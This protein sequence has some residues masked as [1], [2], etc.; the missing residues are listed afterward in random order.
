MNKTIEYLKNTLL[1]S[2]SDEEQEHLA[3]AIASLYK[4]EPMPIIFDNDDLNI[5]PIC[6]THVKTDDKYCSYC[7]HAI[8]L[9][10]GDE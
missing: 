7:G 9:E 5:C 6:Q 1:K 10:I 3:I 4:Q 2:D 8:Y